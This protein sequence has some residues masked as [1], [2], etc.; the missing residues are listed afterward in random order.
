MTLELLKEHLNLLV[1]YTKLI[2]GNRGFE[3]IQKDQLTV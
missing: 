3:Y 1:K 2:I